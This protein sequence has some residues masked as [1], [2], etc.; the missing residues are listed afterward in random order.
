MDEVAMVSCKVKEFCKAHSLDDRRAYHMALAVEE[1]AGNVIEHGFSKDSRKHSLDVRV[2]KKSDGYILRIRDDCYMFDPVKQ[3]ELFSDKDILRH[4][5]L[6]MV[7]G[8]AKDVK[9]TS[10]LKLNNLLVRI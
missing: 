4:I 7:F 9:Y 6:R 5:G 2:I 10:I 3:M 8:T 1:M